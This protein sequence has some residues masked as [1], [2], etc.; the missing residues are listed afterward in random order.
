MFKLFY[1]KD[2]DTT[3]FYFQAN[4]NFDVDVDVV[5]LA[6]IIEMI[7]QSLNIQQFERGNVEII[8]VLFFIYM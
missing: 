1:K 3:K 6:V 5:V 8:H 4:F 2:G 7:K